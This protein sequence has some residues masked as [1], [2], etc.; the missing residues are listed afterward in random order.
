M[1]TR[2]NI[3]ETYFDGFRESNH[4]KVL[5]LLA[6][7]VVWVIH[8]HRELHG[9][10]AFDGEIENDQFEGSPKLSVERLVEE[11]DTVVAPH[12]GEG[13][14]RGGAEFRFAGCTVFTFDG[15]LISRVESYVVPLS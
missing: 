8:G 7:D 1:A 13:K 14:L 11:D 10:E 4:A 15:E 6:D 12:F 9:K 2:K 3:V 5:A